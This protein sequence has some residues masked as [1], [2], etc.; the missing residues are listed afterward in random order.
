MSNG[1]IS[2]APSCTHLFTACLDSFIASL[3]FVI[4][5]STLL[6]MEENA[7]ILRKLYKVSLQFAVCKE[8]LRKWD[9]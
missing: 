2:S 1:Q 4:L 6:Q 5:Q 9:G 7:Y 8:R 3:Y